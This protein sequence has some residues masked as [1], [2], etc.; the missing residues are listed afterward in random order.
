LYVGLIFLISSRAQTDARD[1]FPHWDKLAH[2]LEYGVLGYLGQRA[3][4]L[5][6]PRR[7]RTGSAVR[8]GV[9]LACGLMVAVVDE[10]FQTGIAGRVASVGDF[11]ADTAGLIGGLL[12]HLR[13][14]V[15]RA[16]TATGGTA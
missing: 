5:T 13:F 2:C 3:A 7:G 11:L 4:H 10:R 8:M 16:R 12:L 15:R 6:W 14:R 9:V 1:P